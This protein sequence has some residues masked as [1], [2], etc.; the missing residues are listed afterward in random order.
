[1][2]S[3]RAKRSLLGG[4]TFECHMEATRLKAGKRE[5]EKYCE[6]PRSS[7]TRSLDLTKDILIIEL[8]FYLLKAS[9]LVGVGVEGMEWGISSAPGAK[10]VSKSEKF[11]VSPCQGRTTTGG[12]LQAPGPCLAPRPPRRPPLPFPLQAQAPRPAGAPG[13][14][15]RRRWLLQKAWRAA[16][17]GCA[18]VCVQSGSAGCAPSR[19]AMRKQTL[20]QLLRPL[21]A[22][23]PRPSPSPLPPPSRSPRAPLPS[24][25]PPP[26]PRPGHPDPPPALLAPRHPVLLRP[27]RAGCSPTA[28][29]ARARAPRA[30]CGPP[31]TWPPKS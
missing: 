16:A 14:T 12:L 29:R 28:P 25:F 26:F 3:I 31:G 18:P 15:Q 20:W 10:A 9:F 5:A 24:P 30:P 4:T 19:A 23:A 17:R 6:R 22:L 8:L 7:S 13:A 11:Q 1:M 27:A 21:G 2:L